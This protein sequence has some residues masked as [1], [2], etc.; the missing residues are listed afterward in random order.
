[1]K[2]ASRLSDTIRRALSVGAAMPVACLMIAAPAVAQ[3]VPTCWGKPATI[4]VQDGKIVGG[5]DDGKPYEGTLRGTPGDD[6]IVGTAGDDIIIGFD[7]D[8][9][10]CAGPGDDDVSGGPADDSILGGPGG[11]TV[12]GGAGTEGGPGD[13]QIEGDP[14]EQAFTVI[15]K[16]IPD[17]S[18]PAEACTTPLIPRGIFFAQLL[19][20]SL[21]SGAVGRD[22]RNRNAERN[23]DDATI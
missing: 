18:C 6:V 20:L 17:S 2:S 23:I 15:F 1:M 10:I 4:F 12:L 22:T 9:L 16:R 7:G 21:L 5:P 13:D 11:N 19:V 8:D 3:Q 14:S